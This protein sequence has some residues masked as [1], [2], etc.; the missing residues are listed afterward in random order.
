MLDDIETE[1]ADEKEKAKFAKTEEIENIEGIKSVVE[2][3][4]IT[5]IENILKIK[6][7]QKVKSIKEVPDSIAKKFIK[8]TFDRLEPFHRS[9]VCHF[10]EV[11]VY[12][13]SRIL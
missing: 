3:K 11:T 1:L 7:L 8:V 6:S 4:R 12:R 9:T 13:S 5:P 10:I 2:A